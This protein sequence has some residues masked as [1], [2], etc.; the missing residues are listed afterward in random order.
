MAQGLSLTTKTG[1]QTLG[2]KSVP[3][4]IGGRTAGRRRA[5]IAINVRNCR[6]SAFRAAVIPAGV[7]LMEGA[8]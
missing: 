3:A 5:S 8:G 6:G 4:S 1:D 2:T 7:D